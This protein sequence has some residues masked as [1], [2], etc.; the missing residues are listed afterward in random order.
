MTNSTIE[1]WIK[2]KDTFFFTVSDFH[3]CINILFLTRVSTKLIVQK[4]Q[5]QQKCQN[6]IQIPEITI[7]EYGVM[8]LR[9]VM[10]RA[11]AYDDNWF[12]INLR[13]TN[14]REAFCYS[15][16]AD[17][18]FCIRQLEH[19]CIKFITSGHFCVR[20]IAGIVQ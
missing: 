19:P 5:E 15:E 8:M 11:G 17:S 18:K 4:V 14:V 7:C 20:V 9:N 10:R 2:K 1:T 13:K 16:F 12:L 3:A 6:D